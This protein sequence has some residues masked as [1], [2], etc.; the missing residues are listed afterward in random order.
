[1]AKKTKPTSKTAKP[2]AK[3]ASKPAKAPAKVAAKPAAKP[4][5]AAKGAKVATAKPVAAKVAPAKPV[6]GKAAAAKPAPSKP[7]QTKGAA[8]KTAKPAAPV[9]EAVDP[10]KPVRKGI[11]IVTPKPVKKAKTKTPTTSNI[12]HLAGQ[13]LGSG[14]VRKPLIPS[15]PNASAV[16]P[17]GAQG[18]EPEPESNHK[19]KS[20][21]GKKDLERFR[22]ILIRKRAELFG[23]VTTMESEALKGNSGSL[24]NLP[25]HIAEQ[26]SDTYDQ[27]LSLDLAAADR[28][29][30]RE[31]DDA[32]K[33]INDGTYG[34]CELTGKPIKVERL[35]ELPWA[36]H[37][38]EAARLLER[39][40]MTRV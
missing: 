26:G 27:S 7:A 2:V 37:S 14:A 33:R 15:G 9:A 17:L 21:F 29:L 22:Q 12:A 10:K 36:R 40:S 19:A 35:E 30:I 24:S 23:D 8:A 11:T 16:R 20:P 31:I 34:I 1:M 4:V 25:Q 5:P 3:A 38:I 28:K 6:A 39:R 32:L 18:P 13:L